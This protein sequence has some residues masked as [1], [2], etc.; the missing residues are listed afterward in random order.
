MSYI[1]FDGLAD[2]FADQIY[3]GMKGRLRQALLT[4]LYSAHLHADLQQPLQVLD[5]GGG[6]GQMSAWLLAGGHHVDYFD[7]SAEMVERVQASL[8]TDI[9]AGRCQVQQASVLDFTPA[10]PYDLVVL[11]AVLEWLEQPKNTLARAMHWVKPGGVLGVMAYNRHMLAMRNLMRGTLAK[12]RDNQLGG[13]GRGLTPISPLDP[14][15]VKAQ[16]EA[17]GYTVISQAGI[18]TF[19]DLT[20]PTVLSWYDEADVLAMERQLCEQAPYRDLG[21]YVLFL[22][23]REH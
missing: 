11:H 1:S 13:D 20:E 22:A 9:E 7:V 18:R 3:G 2:R 10:Q 5:V 8:A 4:Q 21:R 14:A 15:D 17:G 6:L 12:V 19:S 16:L 23:R